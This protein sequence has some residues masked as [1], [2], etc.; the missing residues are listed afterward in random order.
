MMIIDYLKI[1]GYYKDFSFF[2]PTNDILRMVLNRSYNL[3]G[4][5]GEDDND[6]NDLE[7]GNEERPLG[8][9]DIIRM[10]LQ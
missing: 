2:E 4:N 9:A 3:N 6:D 1:N 10:L 5:N 8:H 7:E